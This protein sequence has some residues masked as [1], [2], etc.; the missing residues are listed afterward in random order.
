MCIVSHT[1]Y[2]T[3][4]ETR[5]MHVPVG[6]RARDFGFKPLGYV[7]T[8]EIHRFDPRPTLVHPD[9]LLAEVVEDLRIHGVY[10]VS[11]ARSTTAFV[12]GHA[13]VNYAN[14]PHHAYHNP[15]RIYC[16]ENDSRLCIFAQRWCIQSEGVS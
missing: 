15:C 4:H 8:T 10:T 6:N 3:V 12:L 16:N 14:D 2:E 13:V 11:N 7:A 1:V 5:G 9:L